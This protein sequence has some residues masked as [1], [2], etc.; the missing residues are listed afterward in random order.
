[1]RGDLEAQL[2]AGGRKSRRLADA[3]TNAVS[4]K[5]IQVT[6]NVRHIVYCAV[7]SGTVI[8]VGD[9]VY[10]D[11]DD[12]K[13]AGSFT[14]TSDLTTTRQNF[15]NVFLGVALDAH[16]AGVAVTNFRVDVSPLSLYTFTADSDAHEIGSLVAPKKQS[17]NALE[18]AILDA[19]STAAEAIG[20]VRRRD[21]SAATT[22][23]ASF[24]SAY[25]G[26]NAA[27]AQ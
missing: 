27:G 17:G 11:T 8:A 9:L 5:L 20:R 16:A 23:V 6:R 2:L 14:W 24:Q 22:V 26:H 3:F 25:W 1:M 19:T 4:L 7:D 13:P 15:A 21:S 12:V 10:L 18:S